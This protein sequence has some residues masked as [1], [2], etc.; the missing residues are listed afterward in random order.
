MMSLIAYVVQNQNQA[1]PAPTHFSRPSDGSPEQEWQCEEFDG[2]RNCDPNLLRATAIVR[3]IPITRINTPHLNRHKQAV[4]DRF[5]R[6]IL[7]AVGHALINSRHTAV[8]FLVVFS[9]GQQAWRCK[10]A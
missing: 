10:G 3:M 6:V 8:E 2:R 1:S 9:G 4:H 7:D 5:V